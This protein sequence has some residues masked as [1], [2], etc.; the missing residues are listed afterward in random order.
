V[1]KK[2]FRLVPRDEADFKQLIKVW[3][4]DFLK[5]P[6]NNHWLLQAG[7]GPYNNG[8]ANLND[9]SQKVSLLGQES[10][11]VN[12]GGTIG[13]PQ[14]PVKRAGTVSLG[15]YLFFPVL[16][17][18]CD[19]IEDPKR[20][21]T[22]CAT[23]FLDGGAQYELSID[24]ERLEDLLVHFRVTT[25]E[26]PV[27]FREDGIYSIF[28]FGKGETKGV[29]DGIWILLLLEAGHHVVHLKADALLPYND[30][31]AP[32]IGRN[33]FRL[34]VTYEIDVDGQI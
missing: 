12:L 25:D 26:F 1:T 16:A 5:T 27:L 28:G 17:K 20:D 18:L 14:S 30:Y 24:N 11:I 10:R 29:V 33:H 3:Y 19:G 6:Y 22:E 34:D 32:Y 8:T 2:T 4:D 7:L 9:R 13:I 23:Q 21:L 31:L 15:T